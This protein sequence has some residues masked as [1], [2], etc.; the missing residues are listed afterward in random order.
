MDLRSQ[1]CF[2]LSRRF[3]PLPAERTVDFAAYGGWRDDSLS[4]SWGVF[5]DDRVA[6]KDVLD[7][8]CGDGPLTL[9]LAKEKRPRR[10][11]G[12]DLNA[13]GISRAEEA[14]AQTVVASG[15][16][17]EFLVGSTDRLPLPAQGFDTL[18][19]FDCLEHVMS[20]LEILRD[21]HRVLRPGGRCLIE[22]FP[23][24]GPWGPHMESLIPI[25]WAHVIFGERA[26]FRAAEK[27][28]DLP[29]FV[30][31]HWD[32]DEQGRKKPN[33][34]RAW[35]SFEEQAYINKLDI[36][37]FRKL[38]ESV[39]FEIARHDMHSFGGSGARRMIGRALM[40]APLIGEYFVSYVLIELL[41]PAER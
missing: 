34:W 39:G 15:V 2:A 21:W 5:S 25:P 30:P 1:A 6:G 23:Y 4:R 37:T 11:V 36:P 29:E 18:L 3:M 38:A 9:Y 31:R 7:F 26:M 33:K 28:Y 16:N 10:I 32:L 12:V 27:I 20:P 19:A 41:R 22:W 14:L 24:K 35:S 40:N 17:V 8:G 13:E